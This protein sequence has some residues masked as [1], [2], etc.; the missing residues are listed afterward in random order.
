[1]T[2]RLRFSL[3]GPRHNRIFHLVALDQNARRNARPIETLAIYDP[4]LKNGQ[5]HKTVRWSTERIKYWLRNGAQPTDSVVKL[6]TLVGCSTRTTVPR[7]HSFHRVASSR[8]TQDTT[9]H[10]LTVV[11]CP[12]ESITPRIFLYS[13]ASHNPC[14][15][16]DLRRNLGRRKSRAGP[17]LGKTRLLDI[18]GSWQRVFAGVH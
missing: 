9:S 2:V 4:Q 1:M 13:A 11:S 8:P 5:E 18:G 6:L 17:E 14:S 7:S 12:S 15:G 3:V 10:P 16:G